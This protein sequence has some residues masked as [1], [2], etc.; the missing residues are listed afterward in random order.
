MENGKKINSQKMKVTCGKIL[1]D[2]DRKKFEVE[3][4]KTD[5]LFAETIAKKN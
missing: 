5:F 2:E 1:K 4:R 3:R